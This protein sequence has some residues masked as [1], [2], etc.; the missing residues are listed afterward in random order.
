MSAYLYTVG[1]GVN[2]VAGF[3]WSQENPLL[4]EI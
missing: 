1:R 4:Y 2:K 3:A